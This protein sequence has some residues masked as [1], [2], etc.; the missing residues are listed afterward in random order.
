MHRVFLLISPM[1][2]L[3][4]ASAPP[5]TFYDMKRYRYGNYVI[6]VSTTGELVQGRKILSKNSH[7]LAKLPASLRRRA[8]EQG[9]G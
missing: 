6:F 7:F 2:D 1:H 5:S 4:G 8:A 9:L 3:G